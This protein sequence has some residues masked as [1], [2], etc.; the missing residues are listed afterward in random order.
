MNIIG[1]VMATGNDATSVITGIAAQGSLT[2]DDTTFSRFQTADNLNWAYIKGIT[3]G[4]MVQYGTIPPFFT[5]TGADGNLYSIYYNGTTFVDLN[6]VA[7]GSSVEHAASH[8]AILGAF[9]QAETIT[10]TQ[11]GLSVTFEFYH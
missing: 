4:A 6:G 2:I 7:L 8:A 10:L 1:A 9:A 5:V 11:G 3:E